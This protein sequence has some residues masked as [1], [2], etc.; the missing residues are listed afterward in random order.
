MVN[1]KTVFKTRVS[2]IGIIANAS[3][4]Q[5][6]SVSKSYDVNNRIQDNF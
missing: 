1:E 2:V 3:L 6:A 4:L 5:F